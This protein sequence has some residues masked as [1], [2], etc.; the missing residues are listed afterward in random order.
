M[1]DREELKSIQDKLPKYMNEH[2]FE[3]ERGELNSEKK[4]K[5]VVSLIY[6][7]APYSETNFSSNSLTAI[8]FSSSVINNIH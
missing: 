8:S 5:T 6:T 1:F 4:H 3:V 7:G 2:G